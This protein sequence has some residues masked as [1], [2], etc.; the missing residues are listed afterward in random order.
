LTSNPT[1]GEWSP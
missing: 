1:A